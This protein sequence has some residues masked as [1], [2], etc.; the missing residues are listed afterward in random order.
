MN[1]CIALVMGNNYIE[2]KHSFTAGPVTLS[3]ER[4]F[5]I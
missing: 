3:S 5:Y 1:K 2:V 4:F